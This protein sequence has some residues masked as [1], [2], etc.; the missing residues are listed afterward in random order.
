MILPPSRNKGGIYPAP[1]QA[2]QIFQPYFKSRAFTGL[3]NLRADGANDLLESIL[4][5]LPER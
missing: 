3:D 4:E 2:C 1:T 5:L